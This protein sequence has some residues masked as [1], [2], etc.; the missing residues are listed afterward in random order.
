MCLR[1]IFPP[2]PFA[3]IDDQRSLGMRQNR[4][5]NQIIVEHHIGGREQAR[6]FERQQFRIA[7]PRAHEVDHSRLSCGHAGTSAS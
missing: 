7:R 3:N 5:R 2:A 1:N 6:R 4:R